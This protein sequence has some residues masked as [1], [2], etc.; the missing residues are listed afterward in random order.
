M[1]QVRGVGRCDS[2]RPKVTTDVEVGGVF[3]FFDG[4]VLGLCL[5]QCLLLC[6]R[7][8]AQPVIGRFESFADPGNISVRRR[9]FVFRHRESLC[10]LTTSFSTSFARTDDFGTF[11]W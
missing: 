2:A 3:S 5:S 7:L 8:I 10:G 1:Q 11:L 4:L 9:K 6:T